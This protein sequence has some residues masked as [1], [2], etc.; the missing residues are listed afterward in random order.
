M[1]PDKSE[2]V[3]GNFQ[4]TEID[5]PLFGI[6]TLGG[7]PRHVTDVIGQ[8][9]NWMPN[10]NLLVAHGNELVDV[11]PNG[12]SR[13]WLNLGDPTSSAFWLRWSPDQKVLRFTLVSPS[14]NSLAEVFADG[15][16]FHPLL[17]GWH[18]D[19]DVASGNWT[20]DGKFFVFQTIHNWGRADLWAIREK[21]DLFHKKN[22]EPVQLTAGPL[23]FYAPQPSLDGK[24]IY[25]IGEQPRSELVRYDS[26]S[27]QF[28][29]YLDGISARSLSFSRDGHWVAYVTY[30][31][32]NLWRCRLDG[33]EKLQL[34]SAPLAVG[35]AQWSPNGR[36]IAIS[37]SFPGTRERLYLQPSAGGTPARASRR[38]S[39]Y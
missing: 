18:T 38:Q 30:P 6:P 19:D 13:S 39:E 12:T 24:R 21:S 28:Q 22:L 7:S 25:A 16:N 23:N 27:R 5:Q 26:K 14:R 35:S 32:S 11:S 10:G 3:L 1:S 20:P 9:G 8:D 17:E 2:L 34:T 33:S 37:A 29:P 4:G 15:T 36:E 31:E